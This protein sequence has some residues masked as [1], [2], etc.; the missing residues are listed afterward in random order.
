MSLALTAGPLVEPV[1][2]AEAKAH[3]RV[4]TAAEDLLISSLILTS[5]LHIEVALG[6]ALITQSWRL[7]LDA[8]PPGDAIPLPLHPVIEVG[9]VTYRSAAGTEATLPASAYLLDPGPPARIVRAAPNWPAT[10]GPAHTVSIA[11]TAGFGPSAADI[12]APIRQA[13]LLLVAHWYEHRDPVEIGHPSAAIPEA[14]SALLAPYR[15]PRL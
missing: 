2:V 12:P 9:A 6:L 5:R 7:T 4:D 13:M 8:W 3:L 1:S 15:R 11:F 10:T 14:V